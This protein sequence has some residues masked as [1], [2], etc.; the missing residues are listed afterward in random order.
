[1]RFIQPAVRMAAGVDFAQGV[2]MDVGVDLS[3]FHAGM[4]E[5]FLYVADVGPAT[6]HVGGATVTPQMARAGFVDAAAFQELFDPVAKI[7][8]ADA[9]AV[10]AEEEGGLLRQV[11]EERAGFDEKAVEPSGGALADGQHP[12]FASLAFADKQGPGVGIVVTVVEIGHLGAPDAGGVE[13]F[14]HGAVPQAEGVGGV[15]NGEQEVDFLFVEGFRELGGLFAR[16]VKIGSRVCGDGA[17]AAEPGEEAP[18]AAEPGELGVGDER[19]VA[20]RT[21]VLVK[22]SLVGLNVASDED[23]WIVRAA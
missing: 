23:G 21:S 4:A 12:A 9:H 6:V 3:R 15:G 22:E 8:G 10:A 17:G 16:Q 13:K 2:D 20:A 18:H 5:H 19:P 14:E 1:M 11:V 7:G